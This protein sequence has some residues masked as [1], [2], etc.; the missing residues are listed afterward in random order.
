MTDLALLLSYTVLLGMVVP[1]LLSRARWVTRAPGLAIR[2]WQALSIS[3]LA[4]LLLVGV[5]LMKPW[6]HAAAGAGSLSPSGVVTT[7]LGAALT[8]GIIARVGHIATRELLDARRTRR[9]HVAMLALAGRPLPGHEATLLE[10]DAPAVYCLPRP[11]RII[12]TTGAVHALSHDQLAAALGHERAHLRL[13]HHRLL[14]GSAVLART[15][16]PVPLLRRA[17]REIAVLAELAADDDAANTHPRAT[18]AAALVALARASTPT[19]ALGAGG[20]DTVHRVERLLAPPAPLGLPWRVAGT[21]TAA[22]VLALPG[23]LGCTTVAALLT[24]LAL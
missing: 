9:W 1:Q 8:T 24:L 17:H 6:L 11:R 5:V 7:V 22:S 19:V 21:G 2:L 16:R 4:A 13:R 3:W 18:L 12:A 14:A 10:Q 15:F 23:A 20:H